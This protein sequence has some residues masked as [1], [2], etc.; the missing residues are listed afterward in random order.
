MEG[1]EAI[2]DVLYGDYNPDGKLPITYPKNTNGITLYDHKPME[3]FEMNDYQ[4]LFPFGH[5]L[6]YTTFSTYDLA[7]EK[8]QVSSNE[9]ITV[10][11]NVKN[12][13]QRKG[14][15]TVLLYINDV[16]ASVTRPVKQLK[17]FEKVELESGEVKKLKFVL[18]QHDL[19]F[20][21]IDM[22]RVVEPGQ[23]TVMVG[24]ETKIFRLT[25]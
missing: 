10:T 16:V 11:V 7:L 4:P 2:A 21:G 6:S 17:A 8:E 3:S 19:S 13:G 23:F 5:G 22:K 24:D 1:G 20:I 14:K 9:N 18:S 15:E 25:N 12:T